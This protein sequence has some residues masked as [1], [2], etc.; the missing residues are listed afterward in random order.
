MQ[1]AC[2]RY[3]EL[4][5]TSRLFADYSYHFDKVAPF[6][7]HNPH[8][9][10]SLKRAVA[11]IQFPVERRAALVAALK[12]QNGDSPALQRLAQ[13]G[14]V[15]VVT[16]QQVGLLTGPAYTIYKAVT[17]AALAN[18]LT[19]SG[20][21]AVPVFWL[22]TEDHD[23]PE[24][25]H[26][27][28]FDG[29]GDSVV[30]RVTAPKE[31]S[32]KP[33]PAGTVPVVNFPLEQLRAALA[34]FP[35]ADEVMAAVEE[36]YKPGSSQG[37]VTMG[38]GFRALL[39]KILSKLD[40]LYLD[41]LDPAI[42]K[43]WAP[44]IVD[45]LK[46]APRLKARLL[47]RTNELTAAG[48]HAQVHVEAKTSLFF[49]LEN[50]ERQT[51]RRK[52][53]EYADLADRATDVSPNALLRPVLQDYLMPTVAYIGGPG[54]LAYLAQSQ[55]LYEELLGRMPVILS[56]SAFTVLDA[57][58][59]KLMERYQMVTAQ[60]FVSQEALKDRIAKALVPESVNTSLNSATSEVTKQVDRLKADLEN[61]DPTLAAAL[62]KSRAKILYQMEKIAKKTAREAMRRDQRAEADAHHLGSLLYPHRH[63]QERFY[64]ILPFL[65]QHGMDL[66]DRLYDTVEIGCPDH[67]VFTI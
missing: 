40:L 32:G 26:A 39:K 8:D 45:A 58:S 59:T 57:R 67:R 52:D 16:G 48:Y 49:L 64:S 10:E 3:T 56:R 43:I 61:F 14:T 4:P 50:G 33:R 65:A 20:T 11:E 29:A 66:V 12:A 38:S 23:F 27:W 28:V 19:D 5:G 9:P 17:A 36:A 31:F 44:A 30:L 41:P 2:I 54:E 6:Y 47:D 42:R 55:V 35:Y 34:S 22:A 63:L 25:D 13:P 46:A 62:G 53:S 51:L 24:I 60:T 15:A 37:G 18:Q 7:G 1:P 21:P